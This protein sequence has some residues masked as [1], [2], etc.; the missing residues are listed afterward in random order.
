MQKY[1][2]QGGYQRYWCPSCHRLFQ[3]TTRQKRQARERL[4][5]WDS[6]VFDRKTT[7]LLAAEQACSP[8]TIRRQLA[9]SI[10][11]RPAADDDHATPVMLVIDTTYF[12]TFGVMVFRCAR[13]KQN[14][15][16]WFVEHET[17]RLYLAGIEQLEKQGYTIA[18][19]VCDGKRW[20][21]G[22]LAR[23]YP[24]QLCQFHMIKTVTRYITKYPRLPAGKELKSIAFTLTKTTKQPFRDDLMD[25]YAKRQSFLEEKTTDPKTGKQWHTHERT[26]QAFASLIASLP[27]LFT[28]RQYP[29]LKIPNTTNTLDGTFPHLKQRINIHRGVNTVTKKKMVETILRGRKTN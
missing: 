29:E 17:N 18:A 4:T 25:W 12:D 6:Y 9:Q 13:R 19:V 2:R 26:R 1:G 16:W 5:L 27:Y 20:L 28:C 14:L 24:T 22:Q 10:Q 21:C 11:T 3:F 15:L 8:R 23:K 7:T